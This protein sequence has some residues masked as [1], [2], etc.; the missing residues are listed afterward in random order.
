MFRLPHTM[1]TTRRA[2]RTDREALH[3]LDA[4]AF[5]GVWR[6]DEEGHDDALHATPVTRFR[7]GGEESRPV[8]YAIAGRAGP[9]GYLQRIA[10]DPSVRRAGWGRAVVADALQWLHRHRVDRTLVNTQAD[11]DAALR[12]YETCGFTRLPVGLCVMERAL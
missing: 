11:N 4:R 9:T 7:V 5:V 12:L 10:V 8:A 2:R 3:A 6:L 1:L